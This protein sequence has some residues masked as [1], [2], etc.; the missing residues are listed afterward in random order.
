MVLKPPQSSYTL[1]EQHVGIS[2]S[3][4]HVNKYP[5]LATRILRGF[6]KSVYSGE[7]PRILF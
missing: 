3:N 2:F 7:L 5:A 6:Q 4:V 1:L